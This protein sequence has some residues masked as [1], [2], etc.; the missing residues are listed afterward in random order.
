MER[1]DY[2]VEQTLV[3]RQGIDPTAV[4][5]LAVEPALERQAL[6]LGRSREAPPE[7][8]KLGPRLGPESGRRAEFVVLAQCS[9]PSRKGSDGTVHPQQ[10]P[11]P[12]PPARG[13]GPAHP[14]ADDGSAGPAAHPQ[15]PRSPGARPSAA[16]PAR[17]PS[18]TT[19]APAPRRLSTSS[20]SA[21]QD[22]RSRQPSNPH[23]GPKKYSSSRSHSSSGDSCSI[24]RS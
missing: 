8:R 20:A 6:L 11:G 1:T 13:T 23:E 10:S 16:P 22:S 24:I 2:V 15:A 17:R 18:R 14:A 19:P 4:A 21:A 9:P 5:P 12:V 7:Q 3:Q